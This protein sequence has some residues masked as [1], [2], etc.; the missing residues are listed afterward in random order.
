VKLPRKTFHEV[1]VDTQKF[2]ALVRRN[3]PNI[4]VLYLTHPIHYYRYLNSRRELCY[5]GEEL[6]RFTPNVFWGTHIPK[7]ECEPVDMDS[8]GPGET[9]HYTPET[10]AKMV[11]AAAERVPVRTSAET[12]W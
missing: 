11:L 1:L 10:Y 5:L 3:N 8:C 6:E 2:I 9:H 7:E 12:V 4:P